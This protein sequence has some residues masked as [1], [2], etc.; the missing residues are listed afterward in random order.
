[1]R[2]FHKYLKVPHSHF[3]VQTYKLSFFIKTGQ[4]HDYQ[5]VRVLKVEIPDTCWTR[6]QAGGT[7]PAF[8]YSEAMLME[9][10]QNVARFVCWNKQRCHKNIYVQPTAHFS[11]LYQSD[12]QS[13]EK[14][15]EFLDV[16]LD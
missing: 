15:V 11:T 4:G 16:V 9:H 5:C 3:N 10:T 6:L 12:K 1:M 14:R 13:P 8:S 2:L 7:G